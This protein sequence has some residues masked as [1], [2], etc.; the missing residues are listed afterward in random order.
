MNDK[1]YLYRYDIKIYSV[2]NGFEEYSYSRR[3]DVSLQLYDI[4][5]ETK[6]GAWIDVYGS[7]R[8]VNLNARK[9]FACRTKEDAKISFLARKTRQFDILSNQLEDIKQALFL[10]SSYNTNVPI[11]S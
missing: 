7:K 8:F 9:Q 5:K 4:L 2:S 6:C 3:V 11:I 10:M 1:K